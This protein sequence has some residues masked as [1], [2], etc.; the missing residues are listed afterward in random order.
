MCVRSFAH[1]LQHA[2][3]VFPR[4]LLDVTSTVHHPLIALRAETNGLLLCL[5]C[6][7]PIIIRV[8]IRGAY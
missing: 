6:A 2:G 5:I 1:H 3:N 8:F 4:R 7:G